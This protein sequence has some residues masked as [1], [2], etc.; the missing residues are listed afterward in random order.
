LSWSGRIGGPIILS[1]VDLSAGRGSFDDFSL[2]SHRRIPA[3][4]A[5]NVIR[6][7]FAIFISNQ[8]APTSTLQLGLGAT[9]YT[10][11]SWNANLV[12]IVGVLTISLQSTTSKIALALGMGTTNTT[13]TSSS[14]ST[15][16][17]S[18][19]QTLTLKIANGTNTDS[20]IGRSFMVK[21]L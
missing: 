9:G 4:A 10:L 15:P 7:S 12:S 5:P 8:G 19:G 1:V 2:E 17:L 16:D 3:L 6:V 14:S 21:L 18:L 11:F 13:F 20:Q